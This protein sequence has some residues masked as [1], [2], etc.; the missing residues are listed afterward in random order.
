MGVPSPP[1]VGHNPQVT[2]PKRVPDPTGGSYNSQ[3]PPRPGRR[4]SPGCAVPHPLHLTST[5]R[6]HCVPLPAP[7]PPRTKTTTG[8]MRRRRRRRCSSR[9][10]AAKRRP[11]GGRRAG[12]E[13]RGRGQD[14][15]RSCD[16]GT[17]AAALSPRRES[18]SGS[19]AGRGGHVGAGLAVAALRRL[20]VPGP[21]WE[22]PRSA[23]RSSGTGRV[24]SL[25]AP[26]QPFPAWHGMARS[27]PARPGV[28]APAAMATPPHSRTAPARSPPPSIFKPPARALAVGFP[29]ARSDWSS[30]SFP[31]ARRLGR[32][33]RRGRV[34]LSDWPEWAEGRPGPQKAPGRAGR[35]GSGGAVVG[36]A[37]GAAP[38]S[39]PL[40]G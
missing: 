1:S 19:R 7:G 25:L 10:A 30:E 22:R 4:G 35:G 15:D 8:F 40:P 37:P 18:A 24:R 20:R 13:R 36:A 26:P 23:R 27:G 17:A 34:L 2:T 6:A 14:C 39:R 12:G 5:I 11:W 9:T 32:D 3:A 33:G 16:C 31:A 38:L 29:G 21:D 28:S